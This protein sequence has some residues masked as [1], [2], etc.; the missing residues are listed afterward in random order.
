MTAILVF[1]IVVIAFGVV[2]R[3]LNRIGITSAMVF[4][5]AGMLASPEALGVVDIDIDEGSVELLAELTLAIVLFTD[6]GR[7]DFSAVWH[8][9]QIPLRLLGLAFP[10]TIVLGLGV[11]AAILTDLNFWQAAVLA[12]ILA[13]TDAA[14]GQPV[15]TNR[16]VPARIRQGLNVESGLNDG[17]SVP[18]LFVF[19][20]IAGIEEESQSSS[21]WTQ[22]VL[23][24]IGLGVAVGLA[25]GLGG[26][27][28][29]NRA[30]R[31]DRVN[32]TFQQLIAIAQA[33]I[34]LTAAEQIGG[35]GLIAA[36]VAGLA[37]GKVCR[38]L[39]ERLLEFTEEEGRL[40]TLGTFFI[41]GVA[42][43]APRIDE[44][45]WQIA[46]YVVLSL[47]LVRMLPVAI[48]MLGM[49]LSNPTKLFLG[50]F[51]PR[52]LA[53]LVLALIVL[54][55]E[56]LIGR[57]QVFTVAV[58]TVLVSVFAHG[59][60]ARPLATAFGRHCERIGTADAPEMQEVKPIPTR[61]FRDSDQAPP[62]A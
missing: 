8:S 28:L 30:L 32:E 21:F 18:I 43:A 34:A 29:L 5:A 15:I 58:I 57:E 1:S 25:V 41:F 23:E 37:A 14:L 52:G 38:P 44:T 62:W 40:L 54:E 39:A 48:S 51:G 11:G 42:F 3:R 10:L 12:T 50:W 7:I 35:S 53:S 9:P 27:W 24:Q 20:G 4:V 60:T 17:L 33:V 47:T 56:A 45:T 16:V 61:G 36:F 55:E 31:R 46:L 19:I 49:G 6:A 59:A 22:F 2:S 13:P 26:A